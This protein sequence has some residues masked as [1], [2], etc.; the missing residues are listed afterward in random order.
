MSSFTAGDGVRPLIGVLIRR[1]TRRIGGGH[2]ADPWRSIAAQSSFIGVK[3]A[4]PGWPYTARRHQ[5]RR[6][7]AMGIDVLAFILGAILLL[8]GIL[9]GGFELKELKIPTVRWPVRI[10]ASLAGAFFITVGVSGI[11]SDQMVANV[12]ARDTFPTR[13]EMRLL[14]ETASNPVTFTIEDQL[15]ETQISE[16]V[17]VLIDGDRK[18]TLTVNQ[19]YPESMMRVT[20]RGPGATATR[21]KQSRALPRAAAST[22]GQ[23]RGSSMWNRAGYSI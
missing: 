14:S 17:T 9:G 20:C 6:R 7:P 21:W 4:E 12:D 18:G 19:H 16:Q 3:G 8:T 10:V 13:T 23:A 5:W 15:G 1:S 11:S 22:Q 2:G